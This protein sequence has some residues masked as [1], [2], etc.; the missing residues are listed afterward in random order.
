MK[1]QVRRFA[2]SRGRSWSAHAVFAC[3]AVLLLAATRGLPPSASAGGANGAAPWSDAVVRERASEGSPYVMGRICLSTGQY[4]FDNVSCPDKGAPQSVQWDSSNGD[5]LVSNE[6]ASGVWVVSAATGAVITTLVGGTGFDAAAVDTENGDIYT[7][8]GFAGN[9]TYVWSGTTFGAIATITVGSGPEA[10][11]FDPANGDLYVANAGSDNVS[12]IDGSTNRVIAN[13]PV[14]DGSVSP[15]DLT[16]DSE[17]GDLYV[18]GDFNT[19]VVVD[20]STDQVVGDLNLGSFG[21]GMAFDPD[22]GELYVPNDGQDTL[23]AINASTGR[24]V[25]NISIYTTYSSSGDDPVTAAFDPATGNI[26]VTNFFSTDI[27][28]VPGSTNTLMLAVPSGSEGWGLAFEPAGGIG[29]AS[30]FGNDTVTV[31]TTPQTYPM[32]F[33]ETGLSPGTNWTVTTF[34]DSS[35]GYFLSKTSNQTSILLNEPNASIGFSV[36]AANYTASPSREVQNVSGAPL[37]IPVTF[38]K[39]PVSSGASSSATEALWYGVSAIVLVAVA[40]LVAVIWV[41]RRRGQPPS[42][43]DPAQ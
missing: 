8:G 1:T 13:V 28:V 25:T 14:G 39:V 2:G 35:I 26:C 20:L 12:V 42:E 22:N 37:E 5:L 34:D 15:S 10:V 9:T 17:T 21:T 31:F 36:S 41:R 19:A 43:T 23:M 16:I 7:V 33:V 29:Y 38:T 27:D 4:L 24:F 3:C 6:Y 11:V 30:N 32:T 40:V 18:T